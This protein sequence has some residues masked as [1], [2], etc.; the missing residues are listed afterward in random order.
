VR[1]MSPGQR[2]VAPAAPGKLTT[3]GLKT[4]GLA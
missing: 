4:D 3:K 1:H 2:A